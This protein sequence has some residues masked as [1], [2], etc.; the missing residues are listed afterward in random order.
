MDSGR[1]ILLICLPF[2]AFCTEEWRTRCLTLERYSLSLWGAQAPELL[3]GEPKLKT[4]GSVFHY[5]NL[6]FTAAR[7]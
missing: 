2:G 6:A 5:G 7:R 3:L 4:V 1:L